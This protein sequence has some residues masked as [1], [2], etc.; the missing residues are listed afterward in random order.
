LFEAVL[1]LFGVDEF[2]FGVEVKG[3]F[4]IAGVKVESFDARVTE[5]LWRLELVLDCDVLYILEVTFLAYAFS[6]KVGIA[7]EGSDLLSV[8]CGLLL[9]EL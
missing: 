9:E 8:M 2:A 4:Q 7:L 6:I 5:P 3:F 1:V